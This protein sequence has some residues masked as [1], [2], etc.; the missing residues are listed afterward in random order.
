VRG[1]GRAEGKGEGG[2]SENT[3]YTCMK[4]PKNKIMLKNK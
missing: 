4:F 1:L 2:S 3:L